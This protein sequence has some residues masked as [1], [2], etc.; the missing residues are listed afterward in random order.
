M[1]KPH[2]WLRAENKPMEQRRA[3][4]PDNAKR[5]TD[6][7]ITLTVE[8]SSQSIFD[9]KDF[10]AAGCSLAEEHSW[11][12]Q[13]PQDA[14]IL[15][16]KELPA[17]DSPLTHRHIYFAHA[18][19]EQAGWQEVLGRFVAGGGSLYD[20]E[21]LTGGDGRRVAAFGFW[22][23]FAGA[24]VAIHAW[25][26]QQNN[27]PLRHLRAYKN[28]QDMIQSL[29]QQL[30]AHRPRLIVIGAK[31]RC[32][33]GA[34]R[35]ADQLG[36][37]VTGWDLEET[38]AGGPFA[39]I[40][41]HDIFVN[42]VFVNKNIPPFLTHHELALPQRRLSVICDVSCDPLSDLNPLP[43]Y[44]ACSD[45]TNP[46]IRIVDGP[47][48]IDLI[49]IDHLPSLLP[50]ESSDDFSTQLLPCLIDLPNDTQGIWRRARD[51]FHAKSGQLS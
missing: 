26:A 39:E 1:S 30:G 8:R 46:C 17:C 25:C 47:T 37:P 24:A 2:L 18:Y 40:T 16:L 36:L 42:C 27:T 38:Q 4:S 35:V 11:Q 34:R 33:R 21:Y 7:G 23:G 10:E 20:L 31:G 19:K 43:L 14:Y 51:L 28:Q 13:A 49:A 48:P 32:G 29:E 5:L 9:D 3:L 41:E 6:Q 12:A 50:A 22:A 15:G 45:F 44:R